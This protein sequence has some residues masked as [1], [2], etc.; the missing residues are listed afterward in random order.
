M[1]GSKNSN[2]IMFYTYVLESLKNGSQYIG[3][4]ADLKRRIEEHNHGTNVSTKAHLPW[5][6]IYYEACMEEEDA[7]RRERYFKTSQGS[8]ALKLR[9]RWYLNKK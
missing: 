8:R 3:Y 9:L 4:S 2:M 1:L 7:K 6:I 5:K